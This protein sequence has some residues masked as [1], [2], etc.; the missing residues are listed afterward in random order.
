[1]KRNLK[2]ALISASLILLLHFATLAQSP[3][4]LLSK[5]AL[6]PILNG[7]LSLNLTPNAN[8]DQTQGLIPDG[9]RLVSQNF[10]LRTDSSGLGTFSGFAQIVAPDGRVIIQGSLR[11]TVGLKARCDPNTSN[12]DCRAPG[13]LV[14][15]FESTQVIVNFTAEPCLLCA[16]P[17]PIYIGGLDGV[18]DLSAP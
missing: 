11:G 3:N 16:S 6:G 17:M 10:S 15:I 1:M 12:N 4:L 5:N 8:C 13:R 9:S 14:G 2:A 7:L 18:I